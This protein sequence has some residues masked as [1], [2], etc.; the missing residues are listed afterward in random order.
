M[1]SN[2]GTDSPRSAFVGISVRIDNL[3]YGGL[4]EDHLGAV[5]YSQ[6]KSALIHLGHFP[7]KPTDEFEKLSFG[8]LDKSL[9]Y[10]K[11]SNMSNFI[12]QL[13]DQKIG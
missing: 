9:V 12:R 7:M 8:E 5:G 11:I 10:P 6:H 2:T 3:P 4:V 1:E 13:S